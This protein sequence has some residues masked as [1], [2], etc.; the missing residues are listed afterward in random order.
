MY[1][2]LRTATAFREFQQCLVRDVGFTLT[3]TDYAFGLAKDSEFKGVFSKAL[4]KM[5]ENGQMTRIQSKSSHSAEGCQKKEKEPAMNLENVKMA[6]SILFLGIIIGI[7]ICL[8]EYIKK[9]CTFKL[10]LFD[11][12]FHP[13]KI[14]N[15]TLCILW[16]LASIFLC[17]ACFVTIQY[18]E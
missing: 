13:Q 4:R 10:E 2:G 5:G 18:F 7:L 14:S 15:R 11:G 3:E 8:L 6:L 1:E 17:G 12:V 9:D 16:F